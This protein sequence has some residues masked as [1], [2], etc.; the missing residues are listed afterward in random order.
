MSLSFPRKKL[1]SDIA[2]RPRDVAELSIKYPPLKWALEAGYVRTAGSKYELSQSGIAVLADSGLG[3]AGKAAM[4][5]L[6]K[7]KGGRILCRQFQPLASGFDYFTEPDHK[8]FPELSAEYLIKNRLV[9]PQEDGL[10]AGISQTF[11]AVQ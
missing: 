4:R 11:V 1:L 10:F 3:V 7:L 6:A 9:R 2:D 5:A 8:P